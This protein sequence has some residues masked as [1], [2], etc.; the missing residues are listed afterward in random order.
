MPRDILS[1]YGKDSGAG[2]VPRARNGGDMP[3]RDVMNY[4]P[5]MGP[6]NINDAKSP[7]LHGHNCGNAGTQGSSSYDSNGQTGSPGLH[8]DVMPKGRQG[9]MTGPGGSTRR[10]IGKG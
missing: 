4:S 9:M 2:P 10:P 5:P 8:G 1:E 3:V 7:G 6:T